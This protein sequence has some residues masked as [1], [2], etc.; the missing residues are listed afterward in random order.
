MDAIDII[1]DYLN[2]LHYYNQSNMLDSL[3]KYLHNDTIVAWFVD[4]GFIEDLDEE[5]QS[6]ILDYYNLHC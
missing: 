6:I 4:V 1:L 2:D 5:Q 3:I